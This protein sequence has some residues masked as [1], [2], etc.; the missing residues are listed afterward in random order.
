[1]N[2][3]IRPFELKIAQSQLEDLHRRLD[4]TRWPGRETVVDWSQG[5]PLQALQE[6]AYYW[7]N[8]YDWRRCEAT[9]NRWGQFSSEFD[10][11]AIH[12][13]HIRSPHADAL[14]LLM[15]HGWPGSVIE[16][17]KV[18]GPLTDPIPYGGNATDAF[19][20]VLP[21]LP[22]YGF[23][24]HPTASGWN[25]EKI[26]R[27]WIELMKR[28]GYERWAAQGGDWG[29]AVTACLGQIAPPALCA[30][31]LNTAFLT[32]PAD[33]SD[34]TPEERQI[35]VDRDHYNRW[36]SA[37]ALQHA[38]G[39]QTLGYGLVDSA[40]G[41]AGWIYER[42]HA[43]TDHTGRVESVLSLDEILDNV[44]LYWLPAAGAS[45]GRLYW[46]SLMN[47]PYGRC[48]TPTGM[49]M[50][51]REMHRASR[52]WAEANYPNLI[53]FGMPSRGGHFAAF[54]QPTLFVNELRSA[55]ASLRTA[56][57]VR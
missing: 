19:H 39:P 33:L 34:V 55:F 57:K 41:Q 7:R 13:L 42:F 25:I 37:Y 53:Y 11:L 21:S 56:G 36:L 16:F 30:I 4:W 27:T 24:G 6:L 52:R 50:F 29:A 51:P 18:I 47:L 1:V 43:W 5:V 40:V 54:E 3:L 49:S 17:N 8:S 48:T 23:S 12:F 38:T 35:L 20:L 31:H 44:M 22:G 28:L 26:A 32:L 9:L 46:E 45:A 14:P 10:G 2:D 15:T